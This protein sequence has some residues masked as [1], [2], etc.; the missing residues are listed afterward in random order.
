MSFPLPP[1]GAVA[2][3]F[4]SQR[5]VADDAGYQ[6][7]AADMER[8]AATMA[9]FLGFIAARNPDGTGIAVS[10]WAD[11]AAAAAWRDQADHQRIR[12]Q[13]RARW[14]D[15]YALSVAEVTRAYEWQRAQP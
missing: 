11:A 4:V 5:S 7:A 15:A 1:A 6:Q 14:Y 13:G 12:D 10:Y 8:I 3:I 9:G 2:V